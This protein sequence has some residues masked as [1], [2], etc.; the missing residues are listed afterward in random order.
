MFEK[1]PGRALFPAGD[2]I[3]VQAMSLAGV[4]SVVSHSGYHDCIISAQLRR[5]IV[6]PY[7]PKPAFLL[8][9]SPQAAVA[10]HATRQGNICPCITPSG[11][12]CFFHQ[13][14]HHRL[15]ESGGNILDLLQAQGA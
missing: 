10:S 7:P 15:L 12:H 2:D 3:E 1:P 6:D 14:V 5:G 4:Q 8:R 11:L 13:D 9:S